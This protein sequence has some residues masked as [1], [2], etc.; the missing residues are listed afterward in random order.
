MTENP[1]TKKHR[2]QLRRRRFKR[3]LMRRELLDK[4]PPSRRRAARDFSPLATAGLLAFVNLVRSDLR[5]RHRERLTATVRGDVLDSTKDR[6][7]GEEKG[8]IKTRNYRDMWRGNRERDSDGLEV[9][10]GTKE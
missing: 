7:Q 1:R 2:R 3:A 8:R 4:P 5:L 9:I 10:L 6:E